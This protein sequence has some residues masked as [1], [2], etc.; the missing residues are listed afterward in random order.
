MDEANRR[1]GRAA[2]VPAATMGGPAKVQ[3]FTKKFEMRISAIYEAVRRA[4][5]TLVFDPRVFGA[6]FILPFIFVP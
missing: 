1:W 6:V 2:V 4:A 5:G 3:T